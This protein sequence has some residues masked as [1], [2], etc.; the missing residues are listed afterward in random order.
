MYEAVIMAGFGG[1]GLIFMGNL[2][3]QAAMEQGLEVAGF[4]N[5]SAEMRGGESNYNLIISDQEIISPIIESPTSLIIMDEPSLVKYEQRL[6]PGGLLMIN[7]SLVKK[8][9][10]RQ[11]VTIIKIP[12]T[13]MAKQMGEVRTANM[14]ALGAY[15]AKHQLIQVDALSATLPLLLTDKPKTLAI[16]QHAL[17][18]GVD[19]IKKYKEV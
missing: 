5:Y 6:I 12:T 17:K 19:W 10:Q 7:S 15:V 18:Q 13:E 9:L 11:D 8:E 4:P 1:Q 3:A 14:V 16:N 2:L